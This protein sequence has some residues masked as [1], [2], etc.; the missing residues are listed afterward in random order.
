M[1]VLP[2]LLT[3][4]ELFHDAQS[5]RISGPRGA[6]TSDDLMNS[7]SNR[8]GREN[9]DGQVSPRRRRQL[10]DRT[11]IDESDEINLLYE[12]DEDDQT[13][14][15]QTVSSVDSYEGMYQYE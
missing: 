14:V 11:A 2:A 1:S 7:G 12:T 9:P 15:V 5:S 3:G 8:C 6:R 10:N 13:R 4:D